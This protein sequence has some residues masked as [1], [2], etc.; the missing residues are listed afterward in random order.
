MSLV[1]KQ[2]QKR[3]EFFSAFSADILVNP[4]NCVGVMGKGLARDFRVR[5]PD[6][7]DVYREICYH[8][9]M[10]VGH[11]ILLKKCANKY[12]NRFVD[13]I[14]FPT[15]D[16]W[17]DDSRME[18]IEEGLE[19]CVSFLD[20]PGR[21]AVFPLLGAGLGGLKETDVK[22]VMCTH[23][24]REDVKS[25]IIITQLKQNSLPAGVPKCF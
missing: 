1:F 25:D 17:R 22:D 8:E 5:Y 7:Y 13:I 14:L 9:D 16:N 4:V 3:G 23:L 10:R 20:D 18:W 12:T 15:K 6:M 11:P 19:N 24:T 21:T 2:I